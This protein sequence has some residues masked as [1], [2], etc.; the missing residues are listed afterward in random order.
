M[1]MISHFKVFTY[2]V[3]YLDD[4][5]QILLRTFFPAENDQDAV[6]LAHFRAP[7]KSVTFELGRAQLRPFTSGYLNE[8]D[9]DNTSISAVLR[10]LNLEDTVFDDEGEPQQ[11]MP[12]IFNDT[13][14]KT[15]QAAA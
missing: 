6:I 11:E 3:I 9:R 10:N 2:A 13:K 5:R 14:K 7:A 8:I 4:Q 1:S 15:P 12:S